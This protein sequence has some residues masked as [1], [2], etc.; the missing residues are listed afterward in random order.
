[1]S[2]EVLVFYD[3]AM[4]AHDPGGGH[5]E[6]PQRLEAIHRALDAASLDSVQWTK[7]PRAT[8][9]QLERVHSSAYVDAID[10]LRGR[11]TQLDPD[12]AVSTGSVEAAYLAAGAAVAAVEQVIAAYARSAFALVR[13][14][15]HHAEADRGMGFCLFN[16]IAV[17][18]AHGVTALGCERVLIV[19][20]DVHH[21]N[22]TQHTFYGRDDVLYFSSHRDPFYPGTGSLE[23]AGIGP[24]EGFTVNVPLPP[25]LGDDEFVSVYREILAPIAETFRPDLV[26]VSAGFDAH[27]D[28]PLGGMNVTEDGFATV[29]RLVRE[30]A[31]RHSDGRLVL[32][33]EGGYDLGGLSASVCA[34]MRVLCER[35]VHGKAPPAGARHEAIVRAKTFH[36]RHWPALREG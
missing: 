35:D 4:L 30:I 31:A 32:V 8:R 3:E 29:C 12:T 19:D 15:G 18:A 9:E 20:W 36:G 7:P 28:D 10:G 22:G 13:P 5:P 24:G 27:G 2:K 34:C 21:G 1:M 26:L 6:R 17:A 14:P 23:E 25:G 33:L 11:S 16:N